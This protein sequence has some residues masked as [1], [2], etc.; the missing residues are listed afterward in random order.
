M[1][2]SHYKNVAS[3]TQLCD[4][5]VPH[6]TFHPRSHVR[7]NYQNPRLHYQK[8][9]N[10]VLLNDST[11]LVPAVVR[12]SRTVLNALEIVLLF[13]YFKRKEISV[14]LQK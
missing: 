11:D 13:P 2:T 8:K 4:T 7:R 10:L 6:H 5:G 14:L 3:W 1:H 9:K 12:W